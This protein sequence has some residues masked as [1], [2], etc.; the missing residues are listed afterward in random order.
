VPLLVTAA[1]TIPASSTF[2]FENS[3]L[4]DPLFLPSTIPSWDAVVHSRNAAAVLAAKLKRFRF[5]AKVWKWVHRFSP[6]LENNCKFLLNLLDF[7]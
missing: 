2:R 4:L 6:F 1:T 5:A 3:W 7:F